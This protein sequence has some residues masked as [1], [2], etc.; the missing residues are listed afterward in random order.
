MLITEM[1]YYIQRVEFR[2]FKFAKLGLDSST[3][4]CFYKGL[5]TSCI[6]KQTVCLLSG[7]WAETLPGLATVTM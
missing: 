3:Q 6:S 1:T 2:S 4:A 7:H 5:L